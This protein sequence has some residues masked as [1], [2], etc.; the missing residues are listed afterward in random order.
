MSSF[1]G[2]LTA[3]T[4]NLLT[5]PRHAT[6]V[7]ATCVTAGPAVRLARREVLAS[8]QR[9]LHLAHAA[10]AHATRACPVQAGAAAGPAVRLARR[11]VLAS[12]QR[13]LHLAHAACAGAVRAGF[14]ARAGRRARNASRASRTGATAVCSTTRVRA[15]AR[16][17]AAE[18]RTRG[19]R[20]CDP[21]R[22][23]GARHA[24]DRRARRSS[25]RAAR[26]CG[27]SRGPIQRSD[28][29]GGQTRQALIARLVAGARTPFRS[30]W[31]GAASPAARDHR[32]D[33][34]DERHP[35]AER[36]C[37]PHILRS[38]PPLGS[39]SKIADT[40]V[41]RA[42]R[43]GRRTSAA[44]RQAARRALLHGGGRLRRDLV[45]VS[46]APQQR[47]RQGAVRRV[48]RLPASRREQRL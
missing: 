41:V 6:L 47:Q 10:C 45:R 22:A 28:A 4:C 46:R 33:Y 5:D 19:A 31:L 42:E 8:A 14:A 23:R 9:A 16:V 29:R 27:P 40:P 15:R 1:R 30:R 24:R 7:R 44:Y 2:R 18:A 11:E 20:V 39:L 12:A 32:N 17:R 13:A 36:D 26:P 35:F 21:T 48:R 37:G 34:G 38:K 43:N 25:S 3:P